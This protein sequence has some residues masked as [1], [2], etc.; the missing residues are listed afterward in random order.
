[1]IRDVMVRL[2]GTK[3]DD[4]RLAAA[5]DIAE[6]FEGQVIGLFL[7]EL[8]PPLERTHAA[9][10]QLERALVEK[11]GQLQRPTEI[12]RFD[13]IAGALG[14]VAAREARSA[15]AFVAMRPN[16]SPAEPDDLTEHVLFG[17]GRHLY[18]VPGGKPL[19]SRFDHI[20]LAWNGSRESARALGEAMP[21]FEK[22]RLVTVVVVVEDAVEVEAVLGRETVHHLKHHG[23]D[24]ILHRVTNKTGNVA[25]TL[26]AEARRLEADLIVL[27]GYGHSR[28]REWLLGG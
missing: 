16:G 11:L 2:D 24:A 14:D 17:S 22:A 12:R 4:A 5:N 19:P 18:V 10:D 20:V 8:P 25:A 3:A 21:Y 6:R 28:L 9:G 23:V 26:L 15:D 7:N 27:G 13:V 1:M